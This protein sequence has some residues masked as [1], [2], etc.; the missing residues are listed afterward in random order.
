VS[1]EI[2]T[3]AHA[4]LITKRHRYEDVVAPPPDGR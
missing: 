1:D 4:R 2:S 3:F